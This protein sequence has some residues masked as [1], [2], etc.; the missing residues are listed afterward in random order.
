MG[1]LDTPGGAAAEPEL[2]V[3]QQIALRHAKAAEK[4]ASQ[5]EA[6]ANYLFSVQAPK[7]EGINA[8]LS[9]DFRK[10]YGI[11]PVETK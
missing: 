7:L 5:V 1:L 4:I 2:T 11:Y 6:I 9:E 3:D 8:S 10:R